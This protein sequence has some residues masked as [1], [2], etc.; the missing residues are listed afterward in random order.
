MCM[1]L[2]ISCKEQNMLLIKESKQVIKH[3]ER[4]KGRY[5]YDYTKRKKNKVEMITQSYIKIST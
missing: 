2:Y 1:Y 4:N 5:S 3:F